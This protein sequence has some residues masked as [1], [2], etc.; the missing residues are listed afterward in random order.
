MA[1]AWERRTFVEATMNQGPQLEPMM[2]YMGEEDE[3]EL[4]ELDG[5]CDEEFDVMAEANGKNPVVKLS[6]EK[7]HSLFKPWKGALVLKLLGKSIS[8][9]T[10]EQRTRTLWK[11]EA[12]YELI[13]LEKGYYLARF[14]TRS[15]YYKVL[16]GGPRITLGHYVPVAKWRPDFRPS[17]ETVNSTQVWVRFPELPLELFDEEVLFAMGNTAG[18][19]IRVDNTTLS[20]EGELC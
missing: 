16:E 18:K 17:M 20:G 4:D 19:A 1:N 2:F 9:K 12:S 11:L 3:R 8:Y 10:M 5:L 13:D 6:A 14:F 15:D 7:Y